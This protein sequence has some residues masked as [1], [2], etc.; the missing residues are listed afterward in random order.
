MNFNDLLGL[1]LVGRIFGDV[2]KF[3]A[4]SSELHD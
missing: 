4:K 3:R 2:I 1:F